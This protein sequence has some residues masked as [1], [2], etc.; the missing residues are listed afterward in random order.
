MEAPIALGVGWH[1]N[2]PMEDYLRIPALSSSAELVLDRSPAHFRERQLNPTDETD[3]MRMGTALHLAVLEADLFA[4]RCIALDPCE[5][6]LKSGKRK[7]EPCGNAGKAY[8]DGVSYCGT[9][10]PT[11]DAPDPEGRVILSAD[12]MQQVE[13]MRDAVLA[14]PEAGAYFRGAGSNELT[15]IARDP[16]TGI[17]LKIRVDRFVDRAAWVHP[18]LKMCPDASADAFAKHA[19]RMGYVRKAAFYRHVF[20]LLGREVTASALIAVEDARPHGCQVFL[21][22]E[23]DI[24]GFRRKIRHNIA[25]Y[26][27]CLER[28]EWPAYESGMRELKLRPWDDPNYDEDEDE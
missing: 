4:A 25:R 21:L 2:V 14:H 17:L 27:H 24:A 10:D 11:P 26:A 3:R 5:A 13:G 28:D 6:E 9:H 22:D 20:D 19:G 7:G 16:D 18:D 12:K 8:R 1:E 23:G 15:G